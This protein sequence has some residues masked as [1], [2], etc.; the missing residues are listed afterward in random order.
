[1]LIEN[2]YTFLVGQIIIIKII[3]DIIFN[4]IA[5]EVLMNPKNVLF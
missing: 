1:M 2:D 5:I 4:T 3:N